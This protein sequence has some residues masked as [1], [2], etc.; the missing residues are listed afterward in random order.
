MPFK[1]PHVIVVGAGIV[2]ASLAYH[3][4]RQRARVTLLDSA[5]QLLANATAQ[6]FAWLTAGYGNSPAYVHLRQ[7][8]IADWHRVTTEFRGRLPID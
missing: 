6:S 3:L 1:Q 5:T 7:A 8:A 4:G 2:G